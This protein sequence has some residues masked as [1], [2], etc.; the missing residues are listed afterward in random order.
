M[1]INHVTVL[2][3]DKERSED[4]YVNKL[5]FKKHP[6]G[7][8]LWVAVGDQF[9]HIT[10]NSGPSVAGAFY[11]FA[12]GVENFGEYLRQV[13]EKGVEIFDIDGANQPIRINKELDAPGRLFFARDPD[14][15]LV[16]FLD[17]KNQ[18]FRPIVRD[19]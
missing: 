7:K 9:I 17:S 1:F 18:F 19:V 8:S 16:E 3:N 6:V 10:Q 11:H 14:G 5:G 12:I 2:V 15:N 13:I 4:F